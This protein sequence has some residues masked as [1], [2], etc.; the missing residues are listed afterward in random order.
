MCTISEDHIIYGSWNI[1]RDRQKI[2]SFWTILCTFTLEI[3]SFYTNVP[4]V[5]IICYTVPEIRHVTDVIHIFHFGLFFALLPHWRS[6]K[7]KCQKNEKT[8]GNIIILHMCTKNNDEM[9]Y[10]PEIWCATDGRTDGQSHIQRWV[11]HLKT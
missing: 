3:S 10:V 8:P 7:S 11:P 9:M 6:K 5:M 2:L 4:K 1:R